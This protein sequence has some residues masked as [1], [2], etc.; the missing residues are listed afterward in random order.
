LGDEGSYVIKGAITEADFSPEI[1]LPLNKIEGLYNLLDTKVDKVE[2]KALSTNDFTTEYKQKLDDIEE[3]AQRNLIEH[4]YINGT[5]AIPS[6]IDGKANSLAIRLS[7]LTPEEE[8]KLR[9]IEQ[10][11]QVNTI[12]HVFLNEE[13]L[14]IKTVK[15]LPKSVNIELIPYTEQE[16]QKLA[17]I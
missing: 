14:A 3:N 8:E 17:D 11:A 15:T 5:E 4:I 9:G 12:E 2:G 7:S 13:E 1:N 10:N 6:V 16:Q